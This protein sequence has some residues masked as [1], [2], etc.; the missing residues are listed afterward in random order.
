MVGWVRLPF[1]RGPLLLPPLLMTVLLHTHVHPIAVNFAP[2][3]LVMLGLVPAWF[4]FLSWWKA[5]L[6]ANVISKW[7]RSGLREKMREKGIPFRPQPH[8]P[9]LV[10]LPCRWMVLSAVMMS[11]WS[12][13]MAG[14]LPTTTPVTWVE[15]LGRVRSLEFDPLLPPLKKP[16]DPSLLV[17]SAGEGDD[18]VVNQMSQAELLE[19]LEI[20]DMFCVPCCTLADSCCSSVGTDE[21]IDSDVDKP[22][23]DS[24]NLCETGP[25]KQTTGSQTPLTE[26]RVL[27]ACANC[28]LF[29]LMGLLSAND[30]AEAIVDTG[31]SCADSLLV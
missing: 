8:P 19:L 18:E 26:A 20:D 11:M 15:S 25:S 3:M 14:P 16:P 28:P 10:S 31:A 9:P 27:A 29:G 17:S 4:H 1:D 5:F 24:T 6:T 21:S 12:V 23:D 13:A 30:V 7:H 22:S 2:M